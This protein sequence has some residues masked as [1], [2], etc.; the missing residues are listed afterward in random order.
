MMRDKINYDEFKLLGEIPL[1]L[2]LRLK[3]ILRR[4][5]KNDGGILIQTS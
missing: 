5:T 1:L 4:K 3:K 2:K